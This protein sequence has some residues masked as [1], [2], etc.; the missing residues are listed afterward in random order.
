MFN[1]SFNLEI[2]VSWEKQLRGN[3][4]KSKNIKNLRINTNKCW[5]KDRIL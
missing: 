2:A 4:K 1:R 5:K 3:I